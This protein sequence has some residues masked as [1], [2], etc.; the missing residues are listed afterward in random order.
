MQLEHKGK[1]SK[2]LRPYD[3]DRFK[4]D[5]DTNAKGKVVDFNLML[6]NCR[7]DFFYK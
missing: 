3:I 4:G 7:G 1:Y 2:V 5:W 6:K